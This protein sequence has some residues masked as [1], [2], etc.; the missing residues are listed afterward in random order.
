MKDLNTS[1]T[2]SSEQPIRACVRYVRHLKHWWSI[3]INLTTN[4]LQLLN[5]TKYRTRLKK[6]QQIPFKRSFVPPVFN[7]RLPEGSKVTGIQCW[8]VA[9]ASSVQRCGQIISNDIKECRW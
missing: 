2:G 3:S 6:T 4:E 5:T 7:G 8:F 1:Y 9:F